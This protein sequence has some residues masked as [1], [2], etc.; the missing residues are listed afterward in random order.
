[1]SMIIKDRIPALKRGYPTVSDKYNVAGGI[2]RSTNGVQIGKL[3]KYTDTLGTYTEATLLNSVDEIAGIL[4][5]VNVKLNRIW[6]DAGTRPT[7]YYNGDTFDLFVDGFIAVE[8][9]DSISTITTP[10]IAAVG[11]LT[12]DLDVVPGKN[13]Y[14]REVDAS[15]AGYLN[16]G[17]NKYTLVANPVQGSMNTYYELSE[18]GK[19][20]S[21]N[22]ITPGKQVAIEL[23]TGNFM[24]SDE[25]N[26]GTANTINNWPGA[27]YTGFV[28]GRLAE[29]EV[30]R[31]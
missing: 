17:A 27:R 29:I 19:D 2:I 21:V 30:R 20:A 26:S 15:G 10:A 7:T 16:D 22:Q 4:L 31:A 25:E 24:T 28:D 11:V 14:T 5:A 6:P 8:L 3:V 12:G 1:M 23:A 13:Y 18:L 9:D